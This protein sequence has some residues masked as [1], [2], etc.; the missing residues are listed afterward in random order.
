MRV[1]WNSLLGEETNRMVQPQHFGPSAGAAVGA[2]SASVQRKLRK[3]SQHPEDPRVFSQAKILIPVG[4]LLSLVLTPTMYFP[5]SEYMQG[6]TD[7]IFSIIVPE[8]TT[9]MKYLFLAHALFRRFGV[10]RDTIWTRFAKLFSRE[11]RK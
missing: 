2:A 1:S 6:E 8:M 7:D 10:D 11:D 3:M 5:I 4:L 9:F